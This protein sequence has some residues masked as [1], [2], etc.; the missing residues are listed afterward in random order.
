MIYEFA[1]D[2][3]V[4][5][6][7]LTDWALFLELSRGFGPGTPRRMSRFPKDWLKR[8]HSLLPSEEQLPPGV[9]PVRR[10]QAAD[11]M[12]RL[13]D[14]GVRNGREWCAESNW[15]ENAVQQDETVPF[16]AVL[17]P[18]PPQRPHFFSP[19]DVLSPEAPAEWEPARGVTFPRTPDGYLGMCSPM[20]RLAKRVVLVDPYARAK[21]SAEKQVVGGIIEL[22]SRNPSATSFTLVGK[23]G[24]ATEDTVDAYR[25]NWGRALARY[26][27]RG[28]Q[29]RIV[30]VADAKMKEP[31]NRYLLTELGGIQTGNGIDGNRPEAIDTAVLLSQSRGC[32][33]GQVLD[34]TW[35]WAWTTFALDLQNRFDM[36]EG[37]FELTSTGFE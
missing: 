14:E 37:P 33:E 1:V 12:K 30:R 5:A 35:D 11:L 26:A 18:S 27:G 17:A 10:K 6:E 13:A 15:V 19:E 3:E 16:R 32:S 8:A 7:A 23:V 31:H 9:G 4:M 36:V 2:P 28:V 34:S 22:L 21:N 29:I 24:I 25:S 20:V